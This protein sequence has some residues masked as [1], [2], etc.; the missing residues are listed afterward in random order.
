MRCY[1]PKGQ[2]PSA[3][4]LKLG[5]KVTDVVPLQRN[6]YLRAMGYDVKEVKKENSPQRQVDPDSDDE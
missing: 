1:I 5:C 4:A 3:T 6:N 2:V